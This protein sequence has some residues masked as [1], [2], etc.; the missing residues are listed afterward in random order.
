MGN[1]PPTSLLEDMTC[2]GM[3][4]YAAKLGFLQPG[5]LRDFMVGSLASVIRKTCGKVEAIDGLKKLYWTSPF[6]ISFHS[7]FSRGKEFNFREG[8]NEPLE[9]L[10]FQLGQT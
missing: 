8:Q 4:Q 3:T 5:C 10:G 1:V 9:W 2:H 7:G 6:Y